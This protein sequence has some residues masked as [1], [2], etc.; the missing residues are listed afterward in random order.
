MSTEVPDHFQTAATQVER[1]ISLLM[2]HFDCVQV[3]CSRV[4]SDRGTEDYYRGAGNWYGRQGMARH[5]LSQDQAQTNAAE[6]AKVMP[7]E[8][9]DD[10]EHWKKL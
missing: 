5:F 8:P 9:P 6:I 10:S 7:Q 1:A 2:E 4:S 3:L